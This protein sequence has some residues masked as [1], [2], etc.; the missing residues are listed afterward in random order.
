MSLERRLI[1]ILIFA[2]G[3]TVL[4]F[5]IRDSQQSAENLRILKANELLWNTTPTIAAIA[6][7]D[8]AGREQPSLS[9]NGDRQIFIDITGDFR[10]GEGQKLGDYLR[11][12][13]IFSVHL[14]LIDNAH[15]VWRTHPSSI[16]VE[17]DRF[18]FRV[19]LFV[20]PD[21]QTGEYQFVVSYANQER[22]R[23]RIRVLP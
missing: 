11:E 16:D 14:E 2:V 19:P 4:Y 13:K 17:G 3:G 1:A 23:S 22:K 8:A 12:S 18:Q 9:L 7:C 21:L 10:P 20:T 6:V 5:F 15:I